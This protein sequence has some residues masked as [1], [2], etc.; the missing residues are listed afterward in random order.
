MSVFG[1]GHPCRQSQISDKEESKLN[2]REEYIDDGYGNQDNHGS[3]IGI[4]IYS[5]IDFDILILEEES[6]T[7]VGCQENKDKFKNDKIGIA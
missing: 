5:L 6:E 2:N 7:A 1:V 4:Y 3:H